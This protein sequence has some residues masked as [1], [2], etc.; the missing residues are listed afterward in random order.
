[1]GIR[2][3]IDTDLD[4]SGIIGSR[5]DS[6]SIL[7]SRYFIIYLCFYQVNQSPTDKHIISQVANRFPNGYV[8]LLSEHS[9]QSNELYG[10]CFSSVALYGIH[11]N[12]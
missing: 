6:S 9:E 1:M 2:V 11:D 3:P 12:I 10:C 4:R 5:L 8:P 7:A